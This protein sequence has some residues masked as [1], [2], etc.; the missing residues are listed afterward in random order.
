MLTKT[1]TH[2]HPLRNGCPS[3]GVEEP[4]QQRG[5]AD[6]ALQEESEVSQEQLPIIQKQSAFGALFLSHMNQCLGLSFVFLNSPKKL[7]ERTERK[8]SLKNCINLD[9]KNLNFLNAEKFKTV[10]TV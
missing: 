7:D 1:T 10:L 8:R 4:S 2:Q 9:F 3:L 5:A 6:T